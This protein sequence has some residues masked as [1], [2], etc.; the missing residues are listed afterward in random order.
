M[1]KEKVLEIEII[2]INDKFSSWY[3]KKI[4]E[5]R[6]KHINPNELDKLDSNILCFGCGEVYPKT[7]FDKERI[8]RVGLYGEY[9]E[10]QIN[11]EIKY[12]NNYD[13]PYFIKNEYVED[14][15]NIVNSVNERYG[16]HKRWRAEK[17]GIYFYVADKGCISDTWEDFDSADNKRYKLGNYFKTEEEA[18][19]VKVELDKFWKKVRA[20][21]IGGDE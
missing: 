20:G 6:L 2:K 13:E 21:E 14:L 9:Y 5:R 18:E 16:I 3:I 17:K 10:Y 7:K 8:D 15:K 1:E 4:N 11:L 12:K 19:K